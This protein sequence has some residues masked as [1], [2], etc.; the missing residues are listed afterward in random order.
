MMKTTLNINKLQANFLERGPNTKNR[1]LPKFG[2]RGQG[3]TLEGANGACP[4]PLDTSL[5][6]RL[7]PFWGCGWDAQVKFGWGP[8]PWIFQLLGGGAKLPPDFQLWKQ[9]IENPNIYSP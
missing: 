9:K 6:A 5:A 7:A 4:P 3:W 2:G 8:C 1:K